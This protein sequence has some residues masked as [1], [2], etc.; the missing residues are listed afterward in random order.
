MALSAKLEMRQGQALVMTPQLMQAIKLL[1]MSNVDVT[2][3]VEAELERNPLLER[4]E[5]SDAAISEPFEAP[6][7]DGAGGA[8]EPRDG[9]WSEIDPLPSEATISARADTQTT[10]LYPET[11][12]AREAPSEP[13]ASLGLSATAWSGVGGPPGEGENNLEAYVA[14]ELS[15]ADHLSEQLAVAVKDAQER[16]IGHY[17][18]DLIDEAGY[19]TTALPE[20]AERLGAPLPLVEKVLK[21][22]HGFDPPGVGARNLRE[23][24][25]CQLRERDRLDPAMQALLDH[26]EL[27]ARH[28]FPALRKIC[29]VDDEDLADMI[30]E[31]KRLVPKPG[32]AFG[33][34]MIE[35]VVPDILVRKGPDGGWLVELNS[36][37]LPRLLVNQ[38]YYAQI[39]RRGLG[40]KDK[41]FMQDCLQSANWLVKSLDQ[42]ARTILKV[43]IELVRQQDSFLAHGVEYL[44]PLNLRVI[45]E[46]IGMHESTVSR[47]TSN[48]YLGTPRGIF[49]LKYFFTSAIASAQGGEAHSAEAVRYRI[50]HM[51]DNEKADDILSDDTIVDLLKEAGITIAR[52]TVAKYREALRI[53]SSVQRR[54]AKSTVASAR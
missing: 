18:I 44:R 29:G 11:E 54:R 10:D 5:A 27:L 16:F 23:C 33:H 17:L 50:K 37:S 28:D 8:D 42:R 24:L 34:A 25:A 51:I 31:I 38:V 21:I 14:A 32:L 46:A 19:L 47:V 3:Y 53:P 1:Q 15:L 26:L 20:I 36:D 39:A 52:R 9:D 7:D 30:G 40:E 48:K 13:D 4:E 35:P 2:A 43:G 6:G 49:E 41:V 45:A 12:T 22:I